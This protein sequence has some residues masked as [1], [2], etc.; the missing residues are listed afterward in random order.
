MLIAWPIISKKAFD[1]LGGCSLEELFGLRIK[2]N[3]TV[4]L[5][6]HYLLFFY[7]IVV[8][9]TVETFFWKHYKLLGVH[10]KVEVNSLKYDSVV[11]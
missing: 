1:R 3:N 10:L 11:L 7:F 4:M 5:S 9:V 8:T 6:Q 2:N